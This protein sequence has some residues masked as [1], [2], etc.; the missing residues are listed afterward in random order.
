MRGRLCCLLSVLLLLPSPAMA[1]GTTAHRYIMGRAIDLLPAEL[2]SFFEAN[3]DELVWRVNDPD[4]W[5]VAGWDEG[6]NHFLDFGV[7]EYGPYPFAALPR[8]YDAAVVKFG[9]ATLKGNGLLPWRTAEMFGN[10]RRSFQGMA[11][12]APYSASHVVLFAAVMAHY[13][14]DAHQ[15]LHATINYDGQQTNQRGVHARFESDLFE[16]FQ[17]RLTIAPVLPGPMTSPRDAAFDILLESYRQVAPLLAADQSAARG[18]KTYDDGY[19]NAFF[20]EAKSLLERRITQSIAATAAMILGA[21]VEAGRPAL[22][23][24]PSRPPQLTPA[25]R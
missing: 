6:A 7:E 13:V 20:A 23:V 19:F 3:R 2:K 17:T 10:L 14:Q 16:R 22:R 11:R 18:G 4:L 1:W 5:R 24:P 25:Q 12:N 15:P 21:W 8:D 9:G